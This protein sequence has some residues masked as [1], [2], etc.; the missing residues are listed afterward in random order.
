MISIHKSLSAC[1]EGN[2]DAG[3]DIGLINRHLVKDM[4]KLSAGLCE[5]A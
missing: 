1:E 3:I 2:R 4:I 5:N